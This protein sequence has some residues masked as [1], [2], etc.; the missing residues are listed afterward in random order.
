[1][2]QTNEELKA[3]D[4]QWLEKFNAV[5]AER[6]QYMIKCEDLEAEKKAL[7]TA[8]NQLLSA[9][10]FGG[11]LRQADIEE[12]AAQNHLKLVTASSQR[13]AAAKYYPPKEESES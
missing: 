11:P 6:D 13:K 12:I 2:K 1:M 8:I 9:F 4:A 7:Q 3:L 5:V 10:M